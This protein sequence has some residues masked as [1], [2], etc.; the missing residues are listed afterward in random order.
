MPTPRRRSKDV[1]TLNDVVE[2]SPI[3]TTAPTH[4]DIALRAYQLYQ[5]RGSEH[6]Y[7][8]DDWLQAERELRG[9]NVR[10]ADVAA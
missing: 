7:D 10:I 6:G 9:P 5:E 8:W 3:V 1:E 2:T 4:D